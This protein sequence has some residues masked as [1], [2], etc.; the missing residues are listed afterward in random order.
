MYGGGNGCGD[1]AADVCGVSVYQRVAS[2]PLFPFPFFSLSNAFADIDAAN[3]S[4]DDGK[5]L[6]VHR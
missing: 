5:R 1:G 2:Y 6:D 3:A 4:A